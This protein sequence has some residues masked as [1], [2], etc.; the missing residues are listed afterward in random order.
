MVL[1]LWVFFLSET[2][3]LDFLLSTI[4][5][6]LCYIFFLVLWL[7]IMERLYQLSCDIQKW[8]SPSRFQTGKSQNHFNLYHTVRCWGRPLRKIYHIFYSPYIPSFF[9][10]L[11]SSFSPALWWFDPAGTWSDK[12]ICL[13][14]LG[15]YYVLV[16]HKSAQT[17]LFCG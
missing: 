13:I 15:Q 2:I 8:K 16:V 4:W 17:S 1:T 11:F 7:F 12:Q 14:P 9:C 10:I 5:K 3:V 6:Q